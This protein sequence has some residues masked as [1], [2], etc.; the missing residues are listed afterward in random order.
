MEFEINT[1]HLYIE[2][3]RRKI[4]EK[5]LRNQILDLKGNCKVY[6]RVKPNLCDTK[7]N[8]E[9]HGKGD[10]NKEF[11]IEEDSV[12]Y[13]DK[14]S[15]VLDRVFGPT[16]SQ[17]MVFDELELYV[18]NVLDGYNLCIF[19]YGQ[20]GSGKTHTMEGKKD[21]MI[22]KSLCKIENDLKNKKAIYTAKFIEIYN[23]EGI[24]LLNQNKI[25]I[26]QNGENVNINGINDFRSE[27]ISEIFDLVYKISTRRKSAETA[28]NAFSS[29]S[30]FIFVLDVEIFSEIEVKKGSLCMI[31]LAGSERIANSK[32][33]NDRL[34][35]TQHINKSLSA[36][37]NVFMAI[38]KN[39]PYKPFRDSKLTHLMKDYLSGNSRTVML[40]TIDPNSVEETICS[41]RFATKVSE[42]EIGKAQKNIKYLK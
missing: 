21:G 6:C 42:C 4:Y 15:F 40:V 12:I 17:S 23:D 34:K 36:L 18:E 1:K 25:N 26:K 13:I 11:K 3:D 35:E 8:E 22:Y 27:N 38:K 28:S 2:I 29:R 10:E 24:D 14:K 19:A 30:H 20:T 5:K 31:D 39:S 32:V 16:S 9:T 7:I 33:K 41:L 37:G